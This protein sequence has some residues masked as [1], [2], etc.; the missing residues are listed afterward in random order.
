MLSEARFL[1]FLATRG[2]RRNKSLKQPHILGKGKGGKDFGRQ[3]RGPPAAANL[4]LSEVGK[5]EVGLGSQPL[6][7]HA[8]PISKSLGGSEGGVRCGSQSHGLPA[9]ANP[10]CMEQTNGRGSDSHVATAA[11][12]PKKTQVTARGSGLSDAIAK[13]AQVLQQTNPNDYQEAS[14]PSC[15]PSKKYGAYGKKKEKQE[16]TEALGKQ[17]PIRPCEINKKDRP[18]ETP[19]SIKD[20]NAHACADAHTVPNSEIIIIMKKKLVTTSYP[21][22][23]RTTILIPIGS[24][25]RIINNCSRSFCNHFNPEII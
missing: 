5:G 15:Y 19:T 6:V 7:F 23:N 18:Q 17:A 13:G 1:I 8:A 25:T 14:T 12:E 21:K 2:N 22:S 4:I 3:C 16:R 10:N 20:A 9:A 11:P 24:S